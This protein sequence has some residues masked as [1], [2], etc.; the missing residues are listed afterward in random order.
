MTLEELIEYVN[1]ETLEHHAEA[2]VRSASPRFA[3][4]DSLDGR[5]LSLWPTASLESRAILILLAD[6]IARDE[7]R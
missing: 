4:S 5:L 1:S 3:N 2:V 6:R 7:L